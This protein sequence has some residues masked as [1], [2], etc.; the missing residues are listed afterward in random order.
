MVSGV[1]TNSVDCGS[2]FNGNYYVIYNSP[3]LRIKRA[4]RL[5]E[6][7]EADFPDSIDLKIT[8]KCFTGCPYCHENSCPTGKEFDLEETK[9]VLSVLPKVGIEVAIGGGNVLTCPDKALDLIRWLINRGNI[10]AITLNVKDLLS[11]IRGPEDSP[12]MK[13]LTNTSELSVSLGISIDRELTPIEAEDLNR[14]LF[15]CLMKSVFHVVL[16]IISPKD[17]KRILTN[18]LTY[19]NVLILGFKQFGRA[20][21][22]NPLTDELLGQYRKIL[23][24]IPCP[25][26]SFCTIGFDNLAIEQLNIR[27][28]FSEKFWNSHY[29]GKDFSHSMYVDAVKRTFAP[30]SRSEERVSWD[31]TDII[32]YFKNNHK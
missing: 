21:E 31:D 32:S 17:F 30:T 9:K 24:N 27:S 2:Y 19:N 29:L 13:F 8:N 28:M 12:E 26:T 22:M 5:G 3:N 11:A 15:P 16:G 18:E 4:L 23:N 1:W 25:T 20:S 7:L 14:Y 10:P 6:E